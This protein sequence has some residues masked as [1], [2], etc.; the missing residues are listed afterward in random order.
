[1]KSLISILCKSY[2]SNDVLS[3]QLINKRICV[4]LYLLIK[5]ETYYYML[6]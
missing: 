5:V 3:R 6:V 1:L 2:A 4:F